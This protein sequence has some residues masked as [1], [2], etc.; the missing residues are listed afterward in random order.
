MRKCQGRGMT[1]K[2]RELLWRCIILM[3]GVFFFSMMAA[4]TAM[5][6]EY[7][8]WEDERWAYEGD[9]YYDVMSVDDHILSERLR[10]HVVG[11]RPVYPRKKA[12]SRH[13]S[14]T[15]VI[16]E[17]TSSEVTS[18]N[19]LK[20]DS[21]N[22]MVLS[23]WLTPKLSGGLGT[24]QHGE[25]AGGNTPTIAYSNSRAHKSDSTVDRSQSF[26]STLTGEVEEVLPNGYLVIQARKR[27]SINGEEQTVVVTGTVNPDHMDSNSTVRAEYIMD[28]AVR[29]EG[30]G[31]VTRMNKR[32]WGSKV[33]DFLNPF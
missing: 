31:P 23:S 1:A 25:A 5:G 9:D 13:D 22:N 11:T 26:T 32:G 27:V 20:R 2:E 4:V 12:S 6:A 33:I 16:N 19:D 8:S 17:N 15:I 28:M 21:S 10:N 7:R 29:Y 14:V 3:A 18:S 30:K 24:K